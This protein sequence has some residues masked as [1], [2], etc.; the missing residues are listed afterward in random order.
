MTETQANSSQALIEAAKSKVSNYIHRNGKD[1]WWP[2][3]PG[4]EPSTEVTAWCTLSLS[5]RDEAL[6]KALRFLTKS[7][8]EDGGW[9][10]APSE[11]KSDWCSGPAL[12]ALR[13]VAEKLSDKSA[14]KAFQRGANYL[15]EYPAEIYNIG[16]RIILGAVQGVKATE[17][18]PRGWPWSRGCFHWV[19]PTSYNLYALKIP[20]PTKYKDG[21]K[22]IVTH[23]NKFL[24][25]N[26]CSVGG[27]NHGSHLSLGF[28]LPPFIVTTAE[29]LIALQDF[30]DNKEIERGFDFLLKS[31]SEASEAGQKNSAMALSWM[32]L[33]FDAH[34]RD[35]SKFR[36]KL[37]AGQNPDGSFGP[38]MMVTALASM[39]LNTSAGVN[40]F[41]MTTKTN[42]A[43]ETKQN[44]GS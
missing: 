21:F 12:F 30:P 19:E 25:D 24:L 36:N 9:S 2:Y 15:A 3:L 32:T 22:E 13:S 42:T 39:A 27:W 44:T 43:G 18:Q 8:N 14:D 28:N 34:G 37:A 1:G 10:T 17:N 23:A 29:A 4:R 6:P 7:Q 20:G 40:P 38:N 33:A 35:A 41:K 31:D 16:A 26:P 5:D 11:G